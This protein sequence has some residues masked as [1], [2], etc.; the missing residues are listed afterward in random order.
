MQERVQ[1]LIDESQ[2]IGTIISAWERGFLESVMNQV[3]RGRNLSTKQIDLIHRV[4]AKLRKVKDG[5]PEWEAQ[6][7]DDTRRKWEIALNYYNSTG[8]PYFSTIRNWAIEN[9]GKMPPQNFYKKLVENKYAAKIIKGLTDEPKFPAGSTVMLR[10]DARNGLNYKDYREFREVLLFVVSPTDRAVSPAKGCRIYSLL[11]S[12][13][14]RTFEIEERY[15]KK[16][17]KPKKPKTW[18]D[19]D[20]PF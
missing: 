1:I 8:T 13:S 7:N 5:D 18:E 4:E 16:Y 3:Q 2:Q 17:R 14:A 19:P 11:S 15:I 10:S 6:W 12:E 9:P 20:I